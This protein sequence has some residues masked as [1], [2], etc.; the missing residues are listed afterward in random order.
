MYMYMYVIYVLITRAQFS[1]CC[2]DIYSVL[3]T[4]TC[5]RIT[6]IYTVAHQ[7]NVGMV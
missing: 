4:C 1:N 6:L 7:T 3:H 2:G 5:I